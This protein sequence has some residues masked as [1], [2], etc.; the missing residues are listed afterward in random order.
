MPEGKS[1]LFRLRHGGRTAL[2]VGCEITLDDHLKFNEYHCA[3]SPTIRR[4]KLLSYALG[5]VT[6]MVVGAALS[7]RNDSLAGLVVF[8]ILSVLWLIFYPKYWDHTIRKRMEKLLR[9]GPSGMQPYQ[10]TIR[11]DAEG[12]HAESP[13]GSSVTKWS[14]VEKVEEGESA[15][16][17]YIN[18][19]SAYMLP[20]RAFA[21]AEEYSRFVSEVRLL[22][23]GA[24]GLE[25]LDRTVIES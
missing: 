4:M 17:L 20:R 10:Q 8:G 2:E 25:A 14:A 15:A 11:V 7:L 6:F 21:G 1:L 19:V 24:A 3:H 5:P 23:E 12:L 18:P 22:R 13:R 16:Y 9:E